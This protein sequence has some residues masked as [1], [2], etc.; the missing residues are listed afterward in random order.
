MMDKESGATKEAGQQQV[1][2]VVVSK[3]G[4]ERRAR[5][6]LR[7]QGFET[8]LPM[9][10]FQVVSGPRKGEL[11]AA[12]F[13]PRYLFA[14]VPVNL[15]DW[16]EIF[17]TYGVAGVLGYSQARA[18][19][20]KDALIQRMMDQEEGGFIKLGLPDD[21]VAFARGQRVRC[22]EL[23][24]EGVF[25]EMLHERV[26]EKRCAFLVKGMGRDSRFTI[27]LRKLRSVS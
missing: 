14:R 7:Q 1:W 9:K 26:D 16:R 10:L 23:G 3:P 21:A 6:E 12:P 15:A 27:D 19:G 22:D 5:H 2:I 20:V 24:V 18:Y 8:Y 13:L 11:M 4:Q 25:E 17:S